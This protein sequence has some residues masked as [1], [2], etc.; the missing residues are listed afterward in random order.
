M[1]LSGRLE[2]GTFKDDMDR[3]VESVPDEEEAQGA[4][5]ISR[6]E[7]IGECIRRE[8]EDDHGPEGEE[9]GEVE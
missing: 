2:E 9:G 3:R 1:L 5:R 8:E 7:H 4:R 6:E